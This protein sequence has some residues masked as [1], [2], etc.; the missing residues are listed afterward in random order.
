MAFCA[1]P[2]VWL[3]V[4]AM[5]LETA[6]VFM[7]LGYR[8][9]LSTTTRSVPSSVALAAVKANTTMFQDFI[10]RTTEEDPMSE[11]YNQGMTGI[12]TTVRNRST[13]PLWLGAWVADG[14]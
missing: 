6:L 10:I 9:N 11:W 4:A 7:W 5:T 8:H 14:L 1:R 13:L 3:K 12:S 2:S